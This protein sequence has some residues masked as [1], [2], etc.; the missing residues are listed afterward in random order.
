MGRSPLFQVMFMLQHEA[1]SVEELPDLT[2][3]GLSHE[4]SVAKFDLTLSLTDRKQGLQC[5]VE[6]N[7]DLFEASTITRL[8]DH[9]QAILED[10]VLNPT[11]HTSDIALLTEN[12]RHQVLLNWNAT[13]VAY[14]Q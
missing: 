7:S 14:P 1:S 9:W 5:A 10:I 6:Y 13:R 8:L 3:T 11:R 2:F 12:E 4:N